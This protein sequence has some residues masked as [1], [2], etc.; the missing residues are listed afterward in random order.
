MTRTTYAAIALLFLITAASSE[1]Q[2]CAPDQSPGPPIAIELLNDTSFDWNC[3]DWV[4][5]G[6]ATRISSDPRY[7][8]LDGSGSVQQTVDVDGPWGGPLELLVYVTNSGGT[9]TG[10]ERL[11]IEILDQW[12]GLVETADILSSTSTDGWYSYYLY[13]YDYMTITVRIRYTEATNPSGTVFDVH[14]VALWA[15]L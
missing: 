3:A 12:G 15:P 4:Y 1:A 5:S 11:R 7:V 10:T 14:D 9:S 2:Y 6:D 13:N 8:R